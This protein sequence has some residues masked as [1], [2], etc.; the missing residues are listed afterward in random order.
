MFTRSNIILSAAIVL[1]FAGNA[2]PALAQYNY[3]LY[4]GPHQTWCDVNP[5]CNGWNK[6]LHG[7]SYQ[8][9]ASGHRLLHKRSHGANDRY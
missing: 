5:N 6:S 9:D 8:S 7:P 3:D 2:L 1:G 4:G